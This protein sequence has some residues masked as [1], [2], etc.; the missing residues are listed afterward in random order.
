V[1]P[2]FF[3]EHQKSVSVHPKEEN[4]PRVQ[5]LGGVHGGPPSQRTTRSDLDSPQNL[6]NISSPKAYP[7]QK[8]HKNPSI[9]F[10]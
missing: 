2:I 5:M 7:F 9:S 1:R 6:L 8:I 10:E 4:E 3:W